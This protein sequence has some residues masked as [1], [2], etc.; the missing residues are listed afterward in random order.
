MEGAEA[1][2][3]QIA[4]DTTVQ[5]ATPDV[6]MQPG[7]TL[8]YTL[9]HG[10]ADEDT[11]RQMCTVVLVLKRT[12]ILFVYIHDYMLVAVFVLVGDGS[13]DLRALEEDT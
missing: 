2:S 10:N 5:S 8:F 13:T 9:L 11:R 3:R 6:A 7:S 12:V 1:G 4:V